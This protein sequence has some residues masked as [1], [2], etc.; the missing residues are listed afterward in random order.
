ML[1][2]FFISMLGTMAGLW[3]SVLLLFFCG[4]MFV[5]A[6]MGSADTPKIERGTI[7]YFCLD[8]EVQERFEPGSLMEI[9]QS[10]ESAAPSLDEMLAALSAAASDDRVAALYLDCRG[11]AMGMASRQELREAI[12]DFKEASG[13]PVF[14]YADAYAQGDYL[15][16]TTAD[17]LYLNPM[18]AVDI[19]GIGGMTPFFKNTL[20]MLGIRMQILKVGTFKS[21]VEPFI[22]DEM[23]E[24]ARMQMQQYCDSLWAYAVNAMSD[25]RPLTTDS[26]R[27]M[28]SQVLM[29]RPADFFVESGIVDGLCYRREFDNMLAEAAGVEKASDLNMISPAEYL[30]AN[31]DIAGLMSAV[32]EHIA[33]LYAVGDIVDSGDGGIVGDDMVPEII[34]L[35]DD[36]NV[37]ALVL[38]VN[39]GGGSA[40]ASEQIWEALEYFKSKDKPFYVSMGDYAASGGYYISCGADRI[41]ADETTITGS[42]GVF[43]MIPD[44]SGL[45]TDKLGIN[46]STV[47]TNP[48]AVGITGMTAMTPAQAAAMQASV[49][50]IYETFTGRVATGRSM[51]VDSVKAIA[52]GRVWTGGAALRL[53]LVDELGSLDDA[54]S[55]IASETGIDAAKVVAYPAIEEDMFLRMLRESG[56]LTELRSQAVASG[57]SPQTMEYV[58]FVEKLRAMS[59][60]QARMET[61]IF[62]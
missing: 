20:D 9:I 25:S 19:H 4:M 37:R 17:S 56:G 45:V 55:A 27:S 11:S 36:D 34:S 35:A 18:G 13:K 26:I 8:G 47:E 7:L 31:P 1:K 61:V 58:R 54:I 44:F 30:T 50:D 16:A 51:E 46:F 32:G 23:S 62:R 15:L 49:E 38:R 21:A 33:V 6:L 3:I 39:S 12:V 22:L 24:P 14:A 53:G 48:N 57:L 10:A 5:G 60:Y 28:A 42:I 40:F 52:E 41:F 29:A 59:P 43:G 2:R